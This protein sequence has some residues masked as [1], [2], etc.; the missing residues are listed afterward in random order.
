MSRSRYRSTHY[1]TRRSAEARA[2]RDGGRV[3]RVKFMRDGKL[4]SGHKVVFG[5]R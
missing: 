5:R 2:Q 1:V 4:V 3:E